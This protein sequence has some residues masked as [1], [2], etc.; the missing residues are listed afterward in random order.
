M[1]GGHLGL[2]KVQCMTW[3][4]NVKMKRIAALQWHSGM[5]MECHRGAERSLWVLRLLGRDVP[6]MG[7]Q[8]GVVAFHWDPHRLVYLTMKISIVKYSKSFVHFVYQRDH[9]LESYTC[10]CHWSSLTDGTMISFES[11]RFSKLSV[12][13]DRTIY[14]L[15]TAFINQLNHA[16]PLPFKRNNCKNFHFCVFTSAKWPAMEPFIT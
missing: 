11:K 4:S 9:C 5:N 3:Q 7:I 15:D 16:F 14:L 1:G 2:W 10:I 6:E 13:D 8:H 12:A